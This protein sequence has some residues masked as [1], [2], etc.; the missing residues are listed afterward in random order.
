ME[1][2]QRALAT[3]STK[4]QQEKFRVWFLGAPVFLTLEALFCL[5]MDATSKQLCFKEYHVFIVF[6]RVSTL[7]LG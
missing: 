4:A 7:L 1:N 6:V 2:L 3:C 5:C